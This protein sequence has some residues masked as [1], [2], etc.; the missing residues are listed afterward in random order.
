MDW[1]EVYYGLDLLADALHERAVATVVYFHSD[2]VVH[3]DVRAYRADVG[4]GHASR[5]EVGD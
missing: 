2:C 1:A 5:D 4:T 3:Q